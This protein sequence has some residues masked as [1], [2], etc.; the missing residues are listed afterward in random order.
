MNETWVR[1]LGCC[2][3]TKGQTLPSSFRDCRLCADESRNSLFGSW[4]AE[5]RLGRVCETVDAVLS[6][7]ACVH[8]YFPVCKEVEINSVTNS[9]KN[10]IAP[11]IF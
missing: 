11:I 9:T 5:G 7:V 1:L 4:S 10:R 2:M 8:P 3:G 6:D